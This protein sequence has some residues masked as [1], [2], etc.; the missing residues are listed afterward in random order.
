MKSPKNGI[1]F[2]NP[3]NPDPPP[4]YFGPPYGI[5]LIA[6]SMISAGIKIPITA[7]DF[8]LQERDFMLHSVEKILRKEEPAYLAIATQSCT[9]GGVYE[10]IDLARRINPGINII[11]GGPFATCKY[12]FLLKNFNVDYVVV[13]DGEET[14]VELINNLKE[15]VGPLG[16]KGIAFMRKGKVYFSGERKKILNLDLLPYPAFHLFKGFEKKIN[17]GRS[18]NFTSNFILGRRCTTLK[19]ALLMLSSRGCIYSCNFCPMSKIDKYKVRF[20]SPKYFVD[21][22]AYFYHRYGIRDFVFG[23]N[24]FT[25]SKKRVMEIC[26]LI[27]KKRLKIKWSCMTRSDS[28]DKEMLKAMSAA[29][30]FE[31]SYGVESGSEE[32]QNRIGKRLD[33]LKTREAFEQTR[34]AGIRSILMLMVG[35]TGE[36]ESTIRQTFCYVKGLNPDSVLVKRVKVYPG[37]LIHDLY[38]KQGLLRKSYYKESEFTPPSF[39]CEHSEEELDRLS[40]MLGERRIFI[41]VNNTCNNNC[42]PCRLT[43]KA[44][45]KQIKLTKESIV[46]ASSRCEDIVLYGGEVFLRKDIFKILEFAEKIQI[47]HLSIYGNGRIFFYSGFADRIKKYQC[48]DSFIIPFFGLTQMHDNE[49]RVKGAFDQ[50]MQ[51]IKNLTTASRSFKVKAA[52]YITELNCAMLD[53]L[54]KRLI[55][56]RIKSFHF[57]FLRDSIGLISIPINRLPPITDA[58][59]SLKRAA[60]YLQGEGCEFSFEG[61]TPCLLRGYVQYMSEFHS[62]FNERITY[63]EGLEVCSDLRIKYKAKATGC[64]NCKENSICEGIWKS[65]LNKY[66]E[67]EFVLIK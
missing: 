44:Y 23:D 16:I 15:G 64:C 4:N 61:F 25:L 13:G 63:S 50:T 33:L 10:L 35:N 39:T 40:S 51:G 38:E 46:L 28:V 32:I 58:A 22:V 29:G 21:M 6:A 56:N 1:V 42:Y 24:F 59:E 41:Q 54:I 43:G 11:L 12:D 27:L 34:K 30:C 7:Y 57:I 19:N 60:K 47:R 20:H 36:S 31:I 37:T 48:L 62:P 14:M 17:S 9:R 45:N 67:S 26:R 5:S 55:E 18:I 3:Y 65:Y 52:I 53:K 49:V 8:D 66:G 2:V